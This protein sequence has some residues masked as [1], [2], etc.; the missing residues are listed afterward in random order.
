MLRKGVSYLQPSLC[1]ILEILYSLTLSF[2]ALWFLVVLGM[3][4]KSLSDT[5]SF[6]PESIRKKYNFLSSR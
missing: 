3:L 2:V 4:G 5:L 1:Q 6:E